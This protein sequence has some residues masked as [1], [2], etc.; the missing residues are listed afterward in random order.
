MNVAIT[1][2]SLSRPNALSTDKV[3]RVCYGNNRNPQVKTDEIVSRFPFFCVQQH[4]SEMKTTSQELIH[5]LNWNIRKIYPQVPI[6]KIPRLYT[7]HVTYL[8]CR[9][10]TAIFVIADMRLPHVNS[11]FSD[12]PITKKKLLAHVK[13]R[14]IGDDV[15]CQVAE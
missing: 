8:H 13:S 10:S 11:F 3:T 4:V 14:G 5:R 9:I 15:S 7:P 6:S 2:K 1:C 12:L